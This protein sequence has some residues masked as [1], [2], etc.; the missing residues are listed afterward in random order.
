MILIICVASIWLRW[1]AHLS[2]DGLL[3]L[4]GVHLTALS[5]HHDGHRVPEPAR[6]LPYYLPCALRVPIKKVPA[7]EISRRKYRIRNYHTPSGGRPIRELHMDATVASLTSRTMLQGLS[8]APLVLVQLS[9]ALNDSL[10]PLVV[11]VTHVETG[12]IH[13]AHGKAGQHLRSENRGPEGEPRR[14]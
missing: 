5:V 3:Q 2:L 1:L 11:A 9:N 13:P 10:V 14:L 6:A 12:H 7:V 4:V 8:G